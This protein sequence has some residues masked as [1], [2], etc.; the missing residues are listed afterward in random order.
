MREVH[1]HQHDKNAR[2]TPS[3]FKAFVAIA[4][5]GL[6][7]IFWAVSRE[8]EN[9]CAGLIEAGEILSN[10]SEE[11]TVFSEL[12]S[13]FDRT[14]TDPTGQ[15]KEQWLAELEQVSSQYQE[16]SQ[17][18]LESLSALDHLSKDDMGRKLLDTWRSEIKGISEVTLSKMSGALKDDY[19][20]VESSPT[21]HAAVLGYM[22]AEAGSLSCAN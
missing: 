2:L 1:K 3:G 8:P 16:T 9:K 10:T 18:I 22:L 4:A 19:S 12:G 13:W 5:V 11:L 21:N 6:L 15:T 14:Y 20:N 7:A 17:T